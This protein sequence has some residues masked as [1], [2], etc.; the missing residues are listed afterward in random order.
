MAQP[1]ANQ[2]I[3]LYGFYIMGTLVLNSLD[4]LKFQQPTTFFPVNLH[5]NED[6]C[7]NQKIF[8]ITLFHLYHFSDDEH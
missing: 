2:L 6:F 5:Y 1:N 8:Q 7:D 4:L 3:N